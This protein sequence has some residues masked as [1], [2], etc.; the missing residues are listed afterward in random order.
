MKKPSLYLS[1]LLLS[2]S[3]ASAQSFNL[4]VEHVNVPTNTPTSTYGAASGQAGPWNALRFNFGGLPATNLTDVTGA[5]TGVVAVSSQSGQPNT[6]AACT[7]WGAEEFALYDG[8]VGGSSLTLRIQ[9]LLP[10]SYT[11]YTYGHD[12]GPSGT[13]VTVTP[14]PG[15]P[16]IQLLAGSCPSSPP[17]TLGETHVIS[18]AVV[19][20]GQ[21]LR[22]KVAPALLETPWAFSGVQ[23]IFNSGPQPVG[24]SYCVSVPN[25]TG[26]AST[27]SATATLS[28]PNVASVAANDL[29]LTA[30]NVPANQNGL[31]FYG[32]GQTQAPLG[33]GFLCV[34]GTT[35]RLPAVNSGPAGILTHMVDYTMPPSPATQILPGS[36][37]NF[38]AW[39]RDPAGGGAFFNFQSLE[40]IHFSS[41][42]FTP[43]G[44]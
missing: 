26:L 5:A 21:D 33:N 27:I 8:L 18:Q 28:S 23:I 11:V 24:T 7:G 44:L 15:V 20:A 12:A 34:S 3:L 40:S 36:T 30:I 16:V 17:H 38:Q 39:F 31:F 25:S 2:C 19:G 29:T 14:A 13:A 6:V 10:G 37:W 22:V 42:D 9:N 32:L 1:T 43:L 35:G 41:V 4:D